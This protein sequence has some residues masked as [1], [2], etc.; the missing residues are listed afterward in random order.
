MIDQKDKF[1]PKGVSAEFVGE[2][3]QDQHAVQ[4]VITGAVQLVFI[5]PESIICNPVYRNMLLT[6]AYKQKMVAFVVDEAHCVKTS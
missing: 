6:P 1:S 2:D 5:S 4:N 3:Q